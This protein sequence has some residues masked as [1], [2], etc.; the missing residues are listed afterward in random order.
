VASCAHGSVARVIV[1]AVAL[2]GTP[3]LVPGVAGRAVV[4]A[5]TRAQV[6]DALGELVRDARRVVVLDV[7]ARVPAVRRGVM[8]PALE[9][10][11]I[12]RRWWGWSPRG[13]DGDAPAAGVAASVVLL[14]L[15]AAGWDG[16]TEVVEL[17][18]GSPP[19]AAVAAAREAL[20]DSGARLVVVTG[21]PAPREARTALPDGAPATRSVD[22]GSGAP[23]GDGAPGVAGDGPGSSV[24]WAVLDA[25]A[26]AG[27]QAVERS[28]GEY[29]RRS[30]EVVR[31]SV[32]AHARVATLPG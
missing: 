26:R 2:P 13:A 29:E 5:R 15:G 8:R 1:R 10:A 18:A 12:E 23:L 6:L 3:L 14:A 17:G 21:A 4:L 9:A 7:G 25:L 16:P 22:P 27:E 20:A 11:G 32:P 31:F 30:Y 24:E 19:A 28:T